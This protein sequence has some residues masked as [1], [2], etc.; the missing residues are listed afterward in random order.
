MID[1]E[2]EWPP[3]NRR[4]E[5]NRP[6]SSGSKQGGNQLK[7]LQADRGLGIGATEEQE[8]QEE[9]R[10]HPQK[11]TTKEQTAAEDE[12][13]EPRYRQLAHLVSTRGRF[14]NQTYAE[15]YKDMQAEDL[16]RASLYVEF[17]RGLGNNGHLSPGL[18]TFLKYCTGRENERKEKRWMEG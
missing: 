5:E 13:V 11:S 16:S 14:K 9:S 12:A 6:T 8:Q 1:A 2:R 17:L 4:E 18:S 15:A 10:C 7:H 3:N